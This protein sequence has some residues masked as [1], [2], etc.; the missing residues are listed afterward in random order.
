MRIPVFCIAVFCITSGCATTSSVYE[1]EDLVTVAHNKASDYT[2]L[3]YKTQDGLSKQVLRH[4][5]VCELMLIE[6]KRGEFVL[7]ERGEELRKLEAEA[8]PAVLDRIEH[9]VYETQLR[10]AHNPMN[11]SL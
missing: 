1:E 4:K 7:K 3:I 5:G 10:P 8:V 11:A 9:F 2:L 6:T